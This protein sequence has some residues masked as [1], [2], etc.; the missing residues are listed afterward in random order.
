MQELR[1]TPKQAEFYT[2][3]TIDK[4]PNTAFIG[5]LGSGKTVVGTATTL[6]LLQQHPGIRILLAAPTYDQIS[7][8]SLLTFLEWCPP[9][10]VANH[11]R[12][13]HVI[14]F[15]WK[16]ARGNPSQLIYRSTTEIDRI[17][18]HEYGACWWDESATRICPPLAASVTLAARFTVG[19]K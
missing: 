17:R 9:G 6:T 12:T 3:S 18:A 16:D 19:P 15:V 13:E 10:Y 8:G 11:N 5:G 2:N 4:V 7:Q 1:L 14:D